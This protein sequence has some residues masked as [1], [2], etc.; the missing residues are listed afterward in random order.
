VVREARRGIYAA[1]VVMGMILAA[2]GIAFAQPPSADSEAPF[3]DSGGSET[4]DDTGQ[5][6]RINGH[7]PPRRE[8]VDVV[9]KLRLTGVEDGIG[10]VTVFKDTAYLAA[11]VGECGS[12]G[13][14]IVD[15]S[16]VENPVKIGFIPTDVGSFVAEGVQVIT[17]RTLHFRGDVLIFNNEL[18]AESE[19]PTGGA[20]M[21]DVTDPSN[22]KILAEG[23]GDFD[24][25]GVPD[26]T[27]IAH[28]VHSAFL[29][30]AGIK[31]YAVLVDDE[32]V[33]DVDIF[34]V[35]NPRRP[36]KI[37]EYDLAAMFPQILQPEIPTLTE[38]FFHDVIVKRI[39]E[40]PGQIS[41]LLPGRQVMLA[42][43]WDAGYVALDVSDP[44][45]PIY[46]GDT[47]F[48]NPDPELLESTGDTRVPEGNAH[49]AEFTKDDEYVIGAD[50]DFDPYAL[51]GRNLTDDTPLSAGQGS[52]TPPLEP[53]ET[54]EGETVFVGRACDVD[55]AVPTGDGSQIAVVERGECTFT[56]KVANVEEAGGYTAVLI[57]NREGADACT[58]TLGM[59][60]EG[61][62]PTFGV[63]PRD[64]GF[65]L[66]DEPYNDAACL[67]G[68][69]TATAPI[70][71]G[72]VGDEVSFTS[73]F[74]GWGYVHLYDANRGRMGGAELDTYAIPEAHNP[75][76]AA[77]RGA[78]SVHEVAT[79]A[80]DASLVY[81]SYYAGGFR[82]L[83]IQNNELVEV[84]SFIDRRGSNFW[85]VQVF[86]D[87]NT[88]YVAASDIDYGLYI[89]KYTGGP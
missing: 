23:F 73:Y 19:T 30:Q 58:A 12:S 46:L 2:P 47:D 11:Y 64:Q 24:T 26:E 51:E 33:E 41:Q 22:P 52:D 78:L 48:T 4:A 56:E 29:W 59:S 37:A 54:I 32:E 85:G 50:E 10:D 44:T 9:S 15:I 39:D 14:H 38:V 42:S 35:T 3:D 84:G 34:D 86:S 25:D 21:V 66:F 77:N 71:I 63:I 88:E 74:D 70:P 13:V 60:V 31:A 36:V 75:R 16:D 20:T 7:L 87:N 72:T 76:F 8:N 82:V 83:Q 69:G 68:D 43:Y 28:Q 18:C 67:A 80:V 17:V 57:F 81:L 79:S 27:G 40:I 65:A 5:H 89:F 55:P 6:G 53:G 49:Y 61:G 62:I 1:F 45:T